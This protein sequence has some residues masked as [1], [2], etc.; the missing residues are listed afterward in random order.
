MLSGVRAR[1]HDDAA[2][3]PISSSAASTRA[4]A[5]RRCER[6]RLPGRAG[7]DDAVGAVLDEVARGAGTRRGRQGL[8]PEGVTTAVRI[9]QQLATY[10]TPGEGL[11]GRPV[12]AKLRG[13]LEDAAECVV[14]EDEA[15]LVEQVGAS[16]DGRTATGAASSVDS[17]RSHTKG[18]SRPCGAPSSAAASSEAVVGRSEQLGL[19]SSPPCRTGQT[20]WITQCAG[21]FAAPAASVAS[22]IAA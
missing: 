18:Q 8:G 12:S 7:D 9:S 5:R 13:V 3:S 20:A 16:G 11:P 2:R 14:E 1:A 10:C 4:T 17:R 21:A 6:G 15:K 22:G 19:P